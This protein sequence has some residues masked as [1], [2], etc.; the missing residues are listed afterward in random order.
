MAHGVMKDVERPGSSPFS[1]T[2]RTELIQPQAAEIKGGS[3]QND[4][5]YLGMMRGEQSGKVPA[6]AGADECNWTAVHLARDH[7]QLT[8]QGKI[9]KVAFGEVR[10]GDLKA[11]LPKMLGKKSRLPGFWAGCETVEIDNT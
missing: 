10:D 7:F 2:L 8:G 9:A 11:E 1:H 4:L 3:E 5:S 6:H